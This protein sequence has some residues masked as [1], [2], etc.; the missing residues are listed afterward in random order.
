MRHFGFLTP[1]QRDSLFQQAPGSFDARTDRR[2]LAVALGATL[3]TPG[4]RQD[5]AAR[6]GQL[7]QEGVASAVL[8]LEDAI[9][10]DDVSD[11]ERNVVAQL[12]TLHESGRETPQLFVRVRRPDQVRT[13]V[14]ELG[15]A[16]AA[17]TGFVFPKFTSAVAEDY[18]AALTEARAQ[19]S[20][21]LYAMPVLETGEVLFAET[22]LPELLRIRELLSAAEDAVLAVRIGAT[23]LCGLYGLRRGPDLTIWDLALVREALADIVNVFA[24]DDRFTVT[25]AVWEHFTGTERLFKPQLRQT[26]FGR[27]DLP[28][29]PELRYDLIRH[30][31]DGLIREVVLDQATG[32]VGKTVI[33]PSH[34][35]PVHALS[36]V[37]SDELEDARTT[38]GMTGGGVSG[39]ARATRMIES[40]PHAR[41]AARTMRRAEVFGALREDRTFVDLLHVDEGQA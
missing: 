3:Y 31:L 20:L 17:L 40:R 1:E 14:G 9:P 33:H 23:D 37:T 7:V 21:P 16:A 13:L 32:I 39:N 36:V 2:T 29:A 27:P 10:D 5:Y 22:R 24:R 15:P 26:P 11:G 8:C 19:T 41:W 35:R 4:T 12:R 6:I 25:G 38:L 28:G 18:L 34:V 30:D